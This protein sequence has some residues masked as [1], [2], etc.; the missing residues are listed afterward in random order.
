MSPDSWWE[1]RRSSSRIR[2][3]FIR[4]GK[5]N[6]TNSLHSRQLNSHTMQLLN[7]MQQSF[8]EWKG[9]LFHTTCLH[10]H[11]YSLHATKLCLV[12]R[13]IELV[14]LVNCSL[15]HLKHQL[16]RREFQK[17]YLCIRSTPVYVGLISLT[18][19]R[20]V[21]HSIGNQT[22]CWYTCRSSSSPR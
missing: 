16:D 14:G 20:H 21:A 3:S 18:V 22:N 9:F 7:V 2:V 12:S 5:S 10:T 19:A 11:V 17:F 13:H 6:T 1:I 15:R 8:T 4:K